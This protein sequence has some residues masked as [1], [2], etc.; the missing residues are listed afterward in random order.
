MTQAAYLEQMRQ[1]V[2]AQ[3][4]LTQVALYHGADD[5][6]LCKRMIDALAEMWDRWLRTA[7]A[8]YQSSMKTELQLGN[9]QH[10]KC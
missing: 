8:A 9:R 2:K 7:T 1:D 5:P 6:E 10:A 4:L 3:T